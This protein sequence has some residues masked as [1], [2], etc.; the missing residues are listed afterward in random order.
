[1]LLRI[2]SVGARATKVLVLEVMV[3]LAVA[4]GVIVLEVMALTMAVPR[5]RGFKL[6]IPLLPH[7]LLLS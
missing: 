7:R 5:G 3:V 6:L 1:M 2:V 4:V